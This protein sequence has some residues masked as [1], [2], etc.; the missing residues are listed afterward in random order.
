MRN[1]FIGCLAVLTL[2]ACERTKEQFDFSKKPPDEF[3]VVKRAPLEMPPDFSVRPPTPG[4]PR[5]QELSTSAEARAAV[6]GDPALAQKPRVEAASAGEAV[7]L[8]QAGAGYADPD[9]R[10]R[11][12]AETAELSEELMPG[13]E[14]LKE[15][16]G[17]D[18]QEPAT[19]VDPIGESERIKQNREQGAPITEGETPK[20]EENR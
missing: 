7:L 13:I 5:P 9:I 18:A 19:V 2:S 14:Q 10:T 3:A 16:I 11:V 20:V 6:L 4:A 8:Q 12:D 17:Q 1:I 15:M